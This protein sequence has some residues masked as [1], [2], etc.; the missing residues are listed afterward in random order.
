MVELE[1]QDYEKNKIEYKKIESLLKEKLGEN[2]EVS[3]VGSTAIPDMCGKNI[4]DILVGANSEDEFIRFRQIIE[5]IGYIASQNSKTEIYQFFASRVGET[6]SGDSHIHLVVKNT[7]R[8]REFLI[9]RNYLLE[10]RDE[11]YAYVQCKKKLIEKGITDRKQ[12]RETKSLYVS[13]LI[14]RAKESLK[15]K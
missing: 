2:I 3:H 12:Y 5:E 11:V 7:E 1:I 15:I 10:N 14:K 8:Y 13:Q 6:S 9:L 4:I